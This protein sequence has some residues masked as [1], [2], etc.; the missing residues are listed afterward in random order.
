MALGVPQMGRQPFGMA[1]E[2]LTE[3]VSGV[4]RTVNHLFV[5]A[6]A[7]NIVQVVRVDPDDP[8]GAAVIRTLGVLR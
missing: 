7:S 5:G 1:V 4:S 8:A 2:A 3:T 6:F